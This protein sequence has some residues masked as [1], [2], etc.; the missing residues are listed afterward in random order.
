VQ[1]AAQS[2]RKQHERNRASRDRDISSKGR[3]DNPDRKN[4]GQL[5]CIQQLTGAT[6]AALQHTNIPHSRKTAAQR[7]E[8]FAS[9][10]QLI[11]FFPSVA[12]TK[13]LA[14]CCRRHQHGR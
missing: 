3:C 9:T 7:T 5:N 2:G 8:S 14:P 1:A 12:R 6:P 4:S 11:F 13:H 10:A